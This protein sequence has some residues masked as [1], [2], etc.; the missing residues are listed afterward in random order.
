MKDI[1]EIDGDRLLSRKEVTERYGFSRTTI[2]EWSKKGF[3]RVKH[4]GRNTYY[5]ESDILTFL[6]KPDEQE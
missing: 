3:S 1:I 5:F 6:A 4:I 2:Y